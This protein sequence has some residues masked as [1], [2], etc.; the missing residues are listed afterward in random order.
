MLSW[1]LPTLLSTW[2][3]RFQVVIDRRLRELVPALLAGLLLC[4]ERRRT[5][6]SWF[7]TAGITREFRRAY[8]VVCLTGRRTPVLA[9]SVLH[10]IR[11]TVASTGSD[12][13]KLA[14]DDT[15]SPRY[16]PQVE[17]AGVHHN[18]T[19]GPAHQPFLYGHN[20]VT[21]AWLAEHPQWGTIALPLKAE[22]YVREKDLP[23]IDPERRPVFRT[24]LEQAAGLIE[25]LG[26]QLENEEKPI[27]LAIDGGY[28][29]RPVLAAA[30]REGIAVVGRLR[31]DAALR[32]LPG[33]QPASKR[34]PKPTYGRD[35]I[36]LAKR[37]GHPR[38]WTT[39][40]MVL[41]GEEVTKTY[42]TF[43][44]TWKPAGGVIRVVVVK[45]ADQWVAFF[46]TAVA[47]SVAE[48]L[49][50]VADRNSLEQTFKDVKE[51]WGAGQQQLR[52]LHANV[53]AWHLNLWAYTM[54][55]LWAWDRPEEELVDRSASPWDRAPRR[56]SH[57]DRRKALRRSSLREEFRQ[58]CTGPAQRAKLHAFAEH[59]LR[60]TT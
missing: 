59:L 20:Y 31:C 48:I 24:K 53:G 4:T 11:T 29:K 43:L 57:A 26:K 18:P 12:R 8:R 35:V 13:I 2:I 27:W 38:G 9:G 21:L 15:P 5:C 49:E 52:N 37:A 50:M 19:P 25:W 6:T 3:D 28:A 58:A 10:D 40:A 41:Y 39:A 45:E 36:S 46:T 32:S 30:R 47:A 60:C 22:L 1:T 33:P 51:V 54:V 34:G 16:G 55:E 42:K 7:R 14:L 56:P 23:Q 17:G 44:A